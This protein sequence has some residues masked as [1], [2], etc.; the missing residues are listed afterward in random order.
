MKMR[1]VLHGA[2]DAGALVL[3]D[4]AALTPPRGEVFDSDFN[5]WHNDGKICLLD[6]ASDGD[7]FVALLWDEE[8]DAGEVSSAE[9]FSRSRLEVPA[10]TLALAGIEWAFRLDELVRNPHMGQTTSIPSGSY[11][12]TVWTPDLSDEDEDAFTLELQQ[13][14]SPADFRAWLR[15]ERTNSYFAS[16]LLIYVAILG[17][18]LWFGLNSAILMAPLLPILLFFWVR[19]HRRFADLRSLVQIARLEWERENP[20]LIAHLKRL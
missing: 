2:T 7:Y 12:I 17:G 20:A 19:H 1:I 3:F 13:R 18:I 8:P 14:L 11:Q 16:G 9:L 10:G 4:P 5:A 6:L 15:C